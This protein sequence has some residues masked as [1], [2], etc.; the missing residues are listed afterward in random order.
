LKTARDGLRRIASG[1]LFQ[2]RGA[3]TAK[4]RSPIVVRRVAGTMRSAD[5]AERRLYALTSSSDTVCHCRT[6]GAAAESLLHR[7]ITSLSLPNMNTLVLELHVYYV[8]TDAV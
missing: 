2:T 8:V 6:I 7:L 5:D 1:R 3:V 4:A